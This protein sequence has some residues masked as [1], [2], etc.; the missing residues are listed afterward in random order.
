MRCCGY[1]EFFDEGMA[2]RDARRYRRKGLKGSARRIVETLLACG[3]DG[4]EVLEI[5]GGIGAID[6]ELLEAGAARAT[7]LEL[8]PGYETEAEALARD[9]GLEGR[10]ERRLGDVVVR[11]EVAGRA[12]LV[13]MER[14]VCCYPDAAALVTAAASRSRRMLVLTYPRYGLLAR[15]VI[16]GANALLRVRGNPF[17][18]YAHAPATIAD[19][20]TRAGLRP[21]GPERGVVWRLAAF[22]R[23]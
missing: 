22:E 6:V 14:V 17:R 10:I 3:V 16:A 15:A 7:V 5:G 2:R 21:S 12:D 9:H 11:P 8:S 20:A 4:A 19:A 13:V 18:A 23:A 1:D